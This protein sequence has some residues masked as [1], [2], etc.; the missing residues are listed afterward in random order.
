[1]IEANLTDWQY[2]YVNSKAKYNMLIAGRRAGKTHAMKV[3]MVYDALTKPG[4]LDMYLTPDGSLCHEVFRD[5]VEDRYI[6]QRIKRVEKQPVRQ[7]FWNN[8]S[9]TYMRMFDRP[10]KA[11]GFGFDKVRFDEIQKKAGIA[12]RDDFMR[13]I[14]P[15]IM[16][17]Q[18][19]LTIAG[20]WRGR[21]CWW[22]KWMEANKDNPNYMLI[23]KPTWEGY[24]FIEGKENHPE[25]IDAKA[26]MPKALFDQEI[27]CIPSANANCAFLHDDVT[28]CISGLNETRG[29]TGHEYVIG[30]DLG[31]TRDPSAWV[32]LD[33]TTSA[34]VYAELRPLGERHETGAYELARLQRAFN[35]ATVIIDATGGATGGKHSIDSFTKFYRDKLDSC[36]W[37]KFTTKNKAAMVQELSLA[38]EQCMFKIPENCENLLD[39]LY[40]YEY[41]YDAWGGYK[42]QGPEGHDDDLVVALVLAWSGMRYVGSTANASAITNIT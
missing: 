18:G 19:S 24:Q 27:A 5:I 2:Q 10:D 34:V 32:V 23:N 36:R 6:R 40:S 7:I 11:L 42:Y 1:M 12:G 8:G 14:R 16:D 33:T 26:S 41:S 22:H 35:G 37:V 29:S 39:Q 25:I 20:Q 17:R 4:H 31:R 15:L 38:I 13:V 9:K 3:S 30:V 21:G 28:Q